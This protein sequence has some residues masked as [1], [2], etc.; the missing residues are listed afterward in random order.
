MQ[1]VLTEEE[2][3]A[4]QNKSE[5]DNTKQ[6]A[7]VVLDPIFCDITEDPNMMGK[8]L[9]LTVKLDDLPIDVQKLFKQKAGY[10]TRH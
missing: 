2:L 10:V 3:D 7:K 4:L 1:Y 9:R 6:I 5:N 8:V